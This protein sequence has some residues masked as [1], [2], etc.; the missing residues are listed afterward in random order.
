MA[1]VKTDP[2]EALE[3][4]RSAR[5]KADADAKASD[6]AARASEA[7]SARPMLKPLQAEPQAVSA[8]P[9]K[10]RASS[11]RPNYAHRSTRRVRSVSTWAGPRSVSP[12]R[13]K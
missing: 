3:L 7:A 9:T 12:S 13:T 1:K 8:K 10:Q 2:N 5:R 11:A 6:A 4:N